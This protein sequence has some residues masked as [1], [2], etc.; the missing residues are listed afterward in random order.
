VTDCIST[1]G[2]AARSSPLL[3]GFDAIASFKN[4]VRC[5]RRAARAKA[6]SRD[7]ARFLSEVESNCLEL[8][9]ELLAGTYAPKPYRTFDI[10]DPKPRT[11]SAAAFR[12]RVVHHALCAEILPLLEHDA[13]P[14]SFACRSG[15]GQLRALRMAQ[16]LAQ[17]HRYAL[18]LDVHHFFESMSHEVLK[19]LLRRRLRGDPRVL[20][21]AERFVDAGAPG[22]PAGRG[23]PI[24]N[25][26]SQHFANFYLH[27]L[28]NHLASGL[29]LKAV[30]YMDDVIV[31]GVGK[32][33]LWGAFARVRQFCLDRL[34]ITL[35][36]SVTRL[37]PTSEGVPFLGFRVF[38]ELIRFDNARR[39][40]FIR[41]IRAVERVSGFQ[42]SGNAQ[43]SAASLLGWARHGATLALRRSLASPRMRSMQAPELLP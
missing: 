16:H 2:A 3:T 37:L 36:D 30:R 11:I 43:A 40:R 12:D 5:A 1:A 35:K 9:R 22:S 13:S 28:D 18:K 23:V 39:L 7:T 10:R 24:G 32:A 34:D 21:L 19:R 15:F 4:L 31:F 6:M 17:R 14:R 38:P 8:R 42:H 26:T 41:S 20:W 27:P 33:D 29:R 25:L